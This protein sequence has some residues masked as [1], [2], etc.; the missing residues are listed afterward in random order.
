MHSFSQ[1][2]NIQVQKEADK[3]AAME[4]AQ[5]D[6]LMIQAKKIEKLEAR[7]ATMEQD[8]AFMKE[9]VKQLAAEQTAKVLEQENLGQQNRARAAEEE[10]KETD[11]EGRVKM[12]SPLFNPVPD[13]SIAGGLRL[14]KPQRKETT[15]SEVAEFLRWVAEGE[16]DKAEAM[17]KADHT[18][19]LESGELTDPSGRKFRHITGLQYA[20]WALDWNMWLMLL[21][22]I[23]RYEAQLQAMALEE[24]GTEHGQCFDFS[25][26]LGAYK[27]YI[28]NFDDLLKTR[29]I[30]QMQKNWCEEVGRAQL[31][32]PAHAINEFCRCDRRFPLAD[33]KQAGLPRGR[34]VDRQAPGSDVYTYQL[35]GGGLG[36]TFALSPGD[37]FSKQLAYDWSTQMSARSDREVVAALAEIRLQQRQLL[38]RDLLSNKP[39]FKRTAFAM[40]R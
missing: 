8:L 13:A 10:S 14:W 40:G 19:T 23:P 4:Q 25:E 37:G 38:I 31:R 26:L 7:L 27:R 21:N 35:N 16:Q 9:Q 6:V 2:Q 11:T 17:L 15:P 32:L 20:L 39:D 18:L 34:E 24:N 33:F 30:K 29:N 5:A 22:Y 28:D 1:G 3:K 36:E 12:Y